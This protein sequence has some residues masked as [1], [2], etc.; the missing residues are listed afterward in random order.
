MTNLSNIDLAA[1][2]ERD[3]VALFGQSERYGACPKCGGRDRFHV[4]RWQDRDYFF[5]RQCHVDRGD[6]IE[7]LRWQ[8]GMS[9]GE[10]VKALGVE[11]SLAGKRGPRPT[12]P[13]GV[14]IPEALDEAP[15]ADWQAHV[16]AFVRECSARLWS[17]DG[18]KALAYL[19]NRR[20][21]NDDAIKAFH[22]G[23]SSFDDR[24]HGTWRGI[25]IP[26]FYAGELWS[27]NTR[28]AT[29]EP[30][31]L[32]VAGSRSQL[33]NGDALAGAHG[34]L[35]CGG[36][37]DAMLAQQHA[38]TGVACIT[39][40][41]ETKRPTWEAD[42]LLRD[43]RVFVALDNDAAGDA[44]AQPWAKFGERVRVSDGKDITE[45]WQRDGDLPAWI[46]SLFATGYTDEEFEALALE[47]LGRQGYECSYGP[48]GRI[49]ARRVLQMELETT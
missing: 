24:K 17:A 20:G 9:F 1:L 22:L 13:R 18:T 47:A 43:K 48:D 8:R 6:A 46:R 14:V 36:E 26:T 29:G 2:V 16:L 3:G 5:C 38:P 39:F 21:L 35:I 33:F 7:Y 27:V 19:R 10:A 34:A 40:G 41:S 28:R 37:F 42:Y 11:T 31:Y 15:A 23:F 25:T 44:G 49:I 12:T 30:K 4:R 45:F 32:K